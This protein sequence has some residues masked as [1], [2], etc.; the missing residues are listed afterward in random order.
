[1]SLLDA[2]I[3]IMISQAIVASLFAFSAWIGAQSRSTLG[4]LS[5]AC[6]GIQGS[7]LILVAVAIASIGWFAFQLEVFA[8]ATAKTFGYASGNLE[9]AL[10]VF[11]GIVMMSTAIVGLRGLEKLS[12]LAAPALLFLLLWPLVKALASDFDGT[13]LRFFDDKGEISMSSALIPMISGPALGLLVV[14]DI[15]RFSKTKTGAARA[16]FLSFFLGGVGVFLLAFL[17]GRLTLGSSLVEALPLLNLGFLAVVLLLV[18]AWTTNDSNIYFSSL[19][20]ESSFSY[21]SRWMLALIC[22][23]LGTLVAFFRISREFYSMAQSFRSHVL[24][25]S[26]RDYDRFY[27]ARP[28]MR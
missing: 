11:G 3:A 17:I 1:M 12:V 10:I 28:F 18:A 8:S 19:A 15:S 13:W 21:L 4:M 9:H 6:F 23:V 26:S 20:L 24:S 16:T 2:T 14:P 22:G 27:S 7:K 5:R 25:G